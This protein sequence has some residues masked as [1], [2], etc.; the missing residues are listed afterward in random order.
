[1]LWAPGKVRCLVLIYCEVVPA[2]I[3]RFVAAHRPSQRSIRTLVKLVTLAATLPDGNQETNGPGRLQV[4]T[5]SRS[6]VDL[7]AV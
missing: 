4:R 5:G 1:M 6:L 3:H 7:A 2:E